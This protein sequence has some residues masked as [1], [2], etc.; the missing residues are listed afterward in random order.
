MNNPASSK[1]PGTVP[2]SSLGGDLGEPGLGSVWLKPRYPAANRGFD[3]VTGRNK[4]NINIRD[5]Y[6]TVGMEVIVSYS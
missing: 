4:A 3:A 1:S 2:T 5:A 6:E